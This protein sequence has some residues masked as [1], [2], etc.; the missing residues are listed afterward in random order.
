MYALGIFHLPTF[1]SQKGLMRVWDYAARKNE[2]GSY[3]VNY[4]RNFRVNRTPTEHRSAVN[5]SSNVGNGDPRS[6]TA[7][8]SGYRIVL[9]RRADRSEPA[10]FV[11]ARYRIRESERAGKRDDRVPRK[12]NPEDA[13]SRLGRKEA[14]RKEKSHRG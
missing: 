13:L 6:Y 12:R 7:R 8:V 10:D 3:R 14:A 4:V 11:T 1:R 2:H 9:D 5:F